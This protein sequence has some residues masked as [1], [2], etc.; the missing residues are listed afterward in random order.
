MKLRDALFVADSM[1]CDEAEDLLAAVAV[2][3]VSEKRMLLAYL[4]KLLAD[5]ELEEAKEKHAAAVAAVKMKKTQY[6]VGE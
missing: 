6:G 3:A 5:I 4:N 1:P 2:H